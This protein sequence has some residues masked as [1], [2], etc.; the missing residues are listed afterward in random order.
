MDKIGALA[1]MPGSK[2]YFPG[3]RL[4]GADAAIFSFVATASPANYESPIALRARG[5][6]N[7]MAYKARM[8]GAL[9]FRRVGEVGRGAVF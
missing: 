3:D 5:R 4:S 8:V 2:R 6:G 7:L 1:A 9:F